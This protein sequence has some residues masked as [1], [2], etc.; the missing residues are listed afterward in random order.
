M[1]SPPS[2]KLIPPANEAVEP[3]GGRAR[4]P[5]AAADPHLLN[6]HNVAFVTGAG[7]HL[8]QALFPFRFG[9]PRARGAQIKRALS[10]SFCIRQASY[11]IDQA[12]GK[13]PHASLVVSR[14]TNRASLELLD[15]LQRR[16]VVERLPD[17]QVKI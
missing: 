2:A 13:S 6:R 4:N 9:R 16:P 10:A 1:V 8:V 11:L 7:K 17:A 12:K 15:V 5:I 3:S 14:T